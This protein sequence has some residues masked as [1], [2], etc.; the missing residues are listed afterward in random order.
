MTAARCAGVTAAGARCRH[1]GG[2]PLPGGGG[3][4]PRHA[5]QLLLDRIP[6]DPPPGTAVRVTIADGIAWQEWDAVLPDGSVWRV[7]GEQ[8][9]AC[10]PR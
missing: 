6:A 8:V 9:G 5:G 3:A 7:R 1:R 10:R 4:C 2:W